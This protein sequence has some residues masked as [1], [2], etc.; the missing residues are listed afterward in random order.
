MKIAFCVPGRTQHSDWTR[1]WDEMKNHM[2][3]NNIDHY[4]WQ[5]YDSNIYGCRNSLVSRDLAI[6]REMMP[7]FGG[8]PYDYMMWIDGDIGFRPE[9]VMRLVESGKDIISGVCPMGP[10]QRCPAVSYGPDENGQ[11]MCRYVNIKALD[12]AE[13]DELIEVDCVGF[14]FVAVKKGVFEA[15]PFPWFRTM[16][17]TYERRVSDPSEDFGFC[18]RAGKLGFKVLLHP[19]VRLTHTREVMMRSE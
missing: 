7:C 4:L 11:P 15:M 1:S 18:L 14:G 19:W 5:W 9:D 6:P 16:T 10:T 17:Y 3:R 8:E 13:P 12:S 2:F